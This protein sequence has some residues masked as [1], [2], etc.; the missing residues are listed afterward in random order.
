VGKAKLEDNFTIC[1]FRRI[2][3]ILGNM[4]SQFYKAKI[5][6]RPKIQ[7]VIIDNNS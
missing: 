7:F 2:D 1:K 6:Q 5:K 4:F 3:T